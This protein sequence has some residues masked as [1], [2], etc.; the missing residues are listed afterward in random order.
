MKKYGMS[1]R[2]IRYF[3]Q[4]AESLMMMRGSSPF[5]SMAVRYRKTYETMPAR[6]IAR[7][8][9]ELAEANSFID[10]N[11]IQV[12]R[13]AKGHPLAFAFSQASF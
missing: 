6:E 2:T 13:A 12:Q 3:Q 5:F 7:L 9:I 10:D 8:F 4:Q 1:F 11:G